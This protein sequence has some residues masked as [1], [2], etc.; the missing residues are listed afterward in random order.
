MKNKDVENKLRFF[1]R[2]YAINGNSSF[3]GLFQD[4]MIKSKSYS[5][6]LRE[7]TRDY[8]FYVNRYLALSYI[9]HSLTSVGSSFSTMAFLEKEKVI[10]LSRDPKPT[11]F[12]YSINEPFGHQVIMQYVK[13]YEALVNIDALDDNSGRFKEFEIKHA[14]RLL[15]SE[16]LKE[17]YL[18]LNDLR[19]RIHT[20]GALDLR[21]ELFAHPFKD[22]S[23]G[24]VVFLES[25]TEKV[26]EI[27][28]DLCDEEDRND[29][30]RSDNRIRFF[31]NNYLM[32]V[33]RD[34]M[35]NNKIYFVIKT[36]SR[37]HIKAIYEFMSA[38]RKEKLLD[39]EPLLMVDYGR[40][41]EELKVIL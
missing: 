30:E 34:L 2:N 33:G 11:N 37:K 20:S 6:S 18:Y 7:F 3:D 10:N 26:F 5:Q 40:A 41:V 23:A 17:K 16:Y 13:L 9:Y 29:Y 25:V 4:G 32:S 22:G 8:Q 12:Y 31:C 14:R 27:F 24:S 1:I 19:N 15:D 36:K 35:R 21:N 38:I 39:E 28:K